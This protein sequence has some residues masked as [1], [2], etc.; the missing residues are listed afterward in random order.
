MKELR[1]SIVKVGMPKGCAIKLG[2]IE[3]R[4]VND[5]KDELSELFQEME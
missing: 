3:K 4:W 2:L 5:V 1:T